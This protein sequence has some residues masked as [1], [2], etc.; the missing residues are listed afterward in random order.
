MLCRD[1]TRKAKVHFKLHLTRNV[2]DNKN[3]FF[4]YTS[5]KRKIRGNVGQLLNEVPWRQRIQTR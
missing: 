3:S 2:K 5:A 1:E 4:N